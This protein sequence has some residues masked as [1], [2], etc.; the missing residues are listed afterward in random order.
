MS[1]KQTSCSVL[2]I[3]L[4]L[5]VISFSVQ[6]TDKYWSYSSCGTSWWDYNCWS[7]TFG[8][9]LDGN[10]QPLAGD[11]V[12]LYNAGI[13]NIQISYWNT[14]YPDATLNS[15]TIN[16][17]GSGSMALYQSG[18]NLQ[19]LSETVGDTGT[20]EVVQSGG[21]HSVTN[22]LILGNAATGNGSFS[23]NNTGI[24]STGNDLIVGNDG[25][26]TL[27]IIGGSVTSGSNSFIG[28]HANS[29]GSATV[30][31]TGSSWTGNG[32]FFI[33]VKLYN[34]SRACRP[35]VSTSAKPL[36]VM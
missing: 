26:G 20:A 28:H 29:T 5:T 17:T 35:I 33:G 10:G 3:A 6:A 19:T 18:Y 7:A 31:G 12:Y 23:V 14:A 34:S 30:N 13:D 32:G 9:V 27:S 4:A 11:D 21:T 1:K 36:L 25:T 8:G 16:A 2:C 22:N 24:L 15:L